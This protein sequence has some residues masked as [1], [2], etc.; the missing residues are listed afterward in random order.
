MLNPSVKKNMGCIDGIH[1]CI[2]IR[3]ALILQGFCQQRTVASAAYSEQARIMGNII[4]ALPPPYTAFC[5]MQMRATRCVWVGS[6]VYPLLI[7]WRG[8][9]GGWEVRCCGRSAAL[10]SLCLPCCA[11]AHVVVPGDALDTALA[12]GVASFL[13]GKAPLWAS[14]Q[15]LDTR[16]DCE[17][18]PSSAVLPYTATP[19]NQVAVI[20]GPRGTRMVIG[21]CAFQV[22][23][24]PSSLQPRL[25]A[26]ISPHHFPTP[27]A[28]SLP[29]SA[30]P[31]T[32]IPSTAAVPR[33]CYCHFSRFPPC[34][35]RWTAR[36]WYLTHHPPLPTQMWCVETCNILSLE[37]LTL[38]IRSQQAETVKG[39]RVNCGSGEI[40]RQTSVVALRFPSKHLLWR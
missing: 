1:G 23:I 18:L 19:P 16:T 40:S 15:Q 8:D 35:R 28:P 37:L 5:T 9:V 13:L 26:S 34:R 25:T 24:L 20:S 4:S 36:C 30:L 33:M 7:P 32:P 22:N 27:H 21:G 12:L 31:P 38:E 14:L 11:W 2:V 29:L 3:S 6:W 17:C 39:V 10:M